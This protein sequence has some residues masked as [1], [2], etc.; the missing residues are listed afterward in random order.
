MCVWRNGVF[1]DVRGVGIAFVFVFIS[2]VQNK[3][4]WSIIF[5][6]DIV[7]LDENTNVLDNKLERWQ[8]ILKKNELKIIRIKRN[9]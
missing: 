9:F 7:L 3:G 2:N 5:A 1:Y 6:N 8:E 4:P